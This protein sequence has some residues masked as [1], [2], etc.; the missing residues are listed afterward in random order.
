MW[1]DNETEKD[2]LGAEWW[3]ADR[4]ADA[5]RGLVKQV[6]LLYKLAARVRKSIYQQVIDALSN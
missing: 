6:D 5:I 1:P 2:F 3:D 4:Y